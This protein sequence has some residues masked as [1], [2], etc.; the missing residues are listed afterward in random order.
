VQA[1]KRKLTHQIANAHRARHARPQRRQQQQGYRSRPITGLGARPLDIDPR[2]NPDVVADARELA[3]LPAAQFDAVFCSHNLEHYYPHEGARVLAGFAHVLK[4]DGFAEIRVP[5]IKALMKHVVEAGLDVDDV[6]YTSPAGPITAHDMLYGWSVE[7][8]QSGRD[9]YS[10]KSGFSPRHCSA[11]CAKRVRRRGAGQRAGNLRARCLRVQA[12][13]AAGP[14]G[15]A[16]ACL[17]RARRSGLPVT[18]STAGTL[19]STGG[20]DFARR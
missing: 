14:A 8:E 16:C 19:S 3:V 17:H 7:L 13:A 1:G 20:T 6:V 5:D 11:S 2:G 10:H 4:D 15:A 18:P 9:F 12:A